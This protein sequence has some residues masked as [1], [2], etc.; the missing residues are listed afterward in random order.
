MNNNLS[1]I[2]V[3]VVAVK[4]VDS[5]IKIFTLRAMDNVS[6]PAFTGGSHILV[7]ML[8]GANVYTNAYSLMSDPSDTRQYVIGIRREENSKGG[9]HYMHDVVTIGTK[10]FISEPRNLFPIDPSAKHHLLIA[11]G[12]GITP[13]LSQL[14][15]LQ[16]LGASYELH[17]A[18]RGEEELGFRQSLE[19]SNSLSRCYFYAARELRRLDVGLLLAN[20]DH[21]THVYVCGPL[22]LIDA[23]LSCAQLYKLDNSQVHWERFGADH[24][25]GGSFTVVLA[26]SGV[27]LEVGEGTSILQAIERSNVARVECLCREGVCGTC[28]TL[29]IEGEAEHFDQYLSDE[30]KA[31]QRSLMVCVSRSKSDRLVL[32]L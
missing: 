6:L 9:S 17:Y 13:V 16:R 20:I 21:G 10:L 7:K 12:I 2:A 24:S 28:E 29:I 8:H 14:Y 18:F 26:R 4:Q 1:L 11:G 5:S 31:S 22:E 25:K 30:E 19:Q 3:Q 32:D 27:E 23:V 15:D